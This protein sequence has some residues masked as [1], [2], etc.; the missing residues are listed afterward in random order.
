MVVAA[1]VLRKIN[2]NC[3]KLRE[4]K[5]GTGDGEEICKQIEVKGNLNGNFLGGVSYLS[6]FI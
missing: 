2:G 3:L 5:G 4:K 6:L 1:E